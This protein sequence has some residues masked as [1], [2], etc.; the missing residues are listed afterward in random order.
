M[1]RG[2]PHR[3]RV[4]TMHRRSE[5]MIMPISAEANLTAEQVQALA[6]ED[7]YPGDVRRLPPKT[8]FT[9]SDNLGSYTFVDGDGWH[10][11]EVT[12]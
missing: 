8:E 7:G 3:Q 4:V 12:P 5:P 11:W 1:T 10:L 6:T 9:I 2:T